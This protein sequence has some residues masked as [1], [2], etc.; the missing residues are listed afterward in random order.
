MSSLI[1]KDG[2]WC[3]LLI[4]QIQM[5]FSSGNTLTDA[6]ENNV[7]PAAWAFINPVKLT[8]KIKHHR[9]LYLVVWS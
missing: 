5:L 3:S 9:V 7:L 2:L 4:L 8:D 1:G 6:P